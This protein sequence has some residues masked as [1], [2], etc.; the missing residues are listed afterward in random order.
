MICWKFCGNI[1]IDM[2]AVTIDRTVSGAHIA[3]LDGS[4]KYQNVA[5]VTDYVTAVG[6]NAVIRCWSQATPFQER[7]DMQYESEK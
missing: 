3:A 4:R 7:G 2:Y 6:Y 1:T 5:Y